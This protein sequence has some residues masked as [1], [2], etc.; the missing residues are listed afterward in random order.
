MLKP[1]SQNN[2]KRLYTAYK[3]HQYP[4]FFRHFADDVN[5]NL[6]TQVFSSILTYDI[7][8]DNELKGIFTATINTK[9]K[10]IDL[11]ILLYDGNQLKGLAFETM[12]KFIKA[13]FNH[14]THKVVGT[15]SSDDK[16]ANELL[17]KGGFIKEAT[18]RDISHYNNRYHDDIRWIL[19]IKRFNKIYKKE[20]IL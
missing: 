12:F 19:T 6:F 2:L 1:F 15:V 18:L 9:T 10:N 14:D 16:R 3:E 11:G 17:K 20:S 8:E 5:L 13:S 4:H 7:V